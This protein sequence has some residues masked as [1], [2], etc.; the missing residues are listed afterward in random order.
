MPA[1]MSRRH[2]FAIGALAGI[3]IFCE[4]AL[5]RLFS[6]VQYYH[7]AFL[8]ISVALFGFAVSGVFVMLRAGALGR[9][10]LDAALARYGLLFAAAIPLS[11]YTYL[12]VGLSTVLV[13]WG[14]PSV[15][16]TACE[17]ALLALPFFASGVCISLLLFHGAAEANRLYAADLVCSALGAVSVIPALAL[18]GGPKSMLAASTAAALAT[19]PF[20]GATRAARWLAPALALAAVGA[21]VLVPARAFERWHMRKSGL[22][23][24]TEQIRWNAFSM[25]GVGPE[26]QNP[27]SRSIIIDN[28]VSTAM[29]AFDGTSLGSLPWLRRDFAAPA[30]RVKGGGKVLIIGSGGGRDI[31]V[32]LSYGAE[33]VRAV[34]VNPLVYQTAA[35]LFGDFTGHVYSAPQVQPVI[36]DARSYIANSHERFDVILASLI[37]TWA[38]SSA[39]AFALTEN[40][41]YTQDAF[42]DYYEHLDDDGILSIS[43]W[44]PPETPRLLATA[45]AA[46]EAAGASDVRRH[47]VLLRTAGPRGFGNA[48]STLLM[49]K[50]PFTAEELHTIE[51]FSVETGL[52]VALSPDRVD[53]PVVAEFV[54]AKG[55]ANGAASGIDMSPAT[56][57][58]PFFF[59]MVKPSTQVLRMLGLS[60]PSRLEATAF[61]GNLTATRVLIQLLFAVVL[62]LVVMVAVP[63]L[64]R[65]GAV[66]RPGWLA[67]L[68][69]FAC[70]GLGFILIE[71]GLLQRLILLLGKPVYALAVILSTMLL[72]SGC[73][74]F[75]SGRFGARRL[76]PRLGLLLFSVCGLLVAYALFLP[77][78]LSTL[79]GSPWPVR[80]GAAVVLVALPGFLLGMPFPSGLRALELAGARALVPWVWGINGAMSVMASVSGIILAIE[81]GYTAVF[82]LG[83]ACYGLAAVLLRRWAIGFPPA[84]AA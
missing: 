16:A 39:G 55:A 44:H 14:L 15:L 10:R 24:A 30:H 80:L 81:F 46:W 40:L 83:A 57:E 41:L 50:S 82:L 63:L 34:E 32:A 68:G 38:A 26:T 5:T 8:A 37:D 51:L 20:R 29:T 12:Y 2:Y 49:K 1:A 74:S 76:A 56:D 17:Y 65:G 73:G 45:F 6:V 64:A 78:V 23:V 42:R 31:L 52:A 71:V 22:V 4:I 66:R 13:G 47:A 61:Q 3:T 19:L 18:L 60:E 21:L 7:G 11:F 25:V 79:L 70:L 48:I 53:D 69:Y 43:R 75:V 9:G 84:G 67:I 58:R 77:D 33:H 59:N 27:R 35:E 62:L 54:A 28:S 36:G 72:A